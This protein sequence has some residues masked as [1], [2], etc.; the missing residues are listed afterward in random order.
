MIPF[1]CSDS[2]GSQEKN[3]ERE[4]S[5]LTV[6]FNGGLAGAVENREIDVLKLDGQVTRSTLHG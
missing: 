4:V 5:A 3:S 1:W 2:G 6:K